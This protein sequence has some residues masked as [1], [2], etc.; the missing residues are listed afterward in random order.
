MGQNRD[1]ELFPHP[2]QPLPQTLSQTALPWTVAELRGSHTRLGC[3][4]HLFPSA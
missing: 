4:G 2:F 3:R 1:Q